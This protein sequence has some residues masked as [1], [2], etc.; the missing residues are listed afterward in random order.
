MSESLTTREASPGGTKVNGLDL[1]RVGSHPN[2]WYPIAWSKEVKPGKAHAARFAGEPI[3][4]VRPKEGPVFA[5]ED[6]CAHR[7]IPLSGGVTN[8][9]L[10]LPL[11]VHVVVVVLSERF[12]QPRVTLQGWREPLKSAAV[13]CKQTDK[14]GLIG[15]IDAEVDVHFRHF[16]IKLPQ[17]PIRE[18]ICDS[19]V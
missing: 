9:R 12:V 10:E 8:G 15:L 3:V 18:P 19:S 7:Q 13:A 11:I 4:V 17:I 6:R 5:L 16:E 14:L 2:H 1:R